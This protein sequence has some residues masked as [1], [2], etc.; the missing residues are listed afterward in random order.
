MREAAPSTV[1]ARERPS[2]ARMSPVHATGSRMSPTSPAIAPSQ[3]WQPSVAPAPWRARATPLPSSSR[4]RQRPA[5]GR[6][7][8]LHRHGWPCDGARAQRLCLPSHPLPSSRCRHQPRPGHAIHAAHRPKPPGSGPS[9]AARDHHFAH[10]ALGSTASPSRAADMA[11]HLGAC[12]VVTVLV[13][14]HP[15]AGGVCGHR[16]DAPRGRRLFARVRRVDPI[17]GVMNSVGLVSPSYA[18]AASVYGSVMAAFTPCSPPSALT[19]LGSA[20][21]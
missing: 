11:W 5:H 18:Q 4:R 17:I 16:G 6:R 20:A 12:L 7:H 1:V 3:R 21:A 8:H 2:Q 14:P 13:P 15:L 9:P 19:H 10:W